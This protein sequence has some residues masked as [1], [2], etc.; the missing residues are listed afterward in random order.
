[1]ARWGADRAKRF[2]SIGPAIAAGLPDVNSGTTPANSGGA[3]GPGDEMSIVPGGCSGNQ[4]P[5]ALTWDFSFTGGTFTALT[6]TLEGSTD[7]TNWFTVD[8][9]N[10]GVAK[11]KSVANQPYIYWRLNITVYTAN[12]GTP[13]VSGGITL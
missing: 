8:S 10:T 5:P 12:V 3:T 7:G 9:D 11:A 1:M 4:F 6:I 13:I 2:Q